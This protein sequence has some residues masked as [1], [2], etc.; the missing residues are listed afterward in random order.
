[1]RNNLRVLNWNCRGFWEKRH[2]IEHFSQHYDIISLSETFL[3]PSHPQFNLQ[4]FKYVRIDRQTNTYG[5]G[6]IV[7]I[8]QEIEYKRIFISNTPTKMECVA[9]QLI[10]GNDKLSLI[11]VYCPPNASLDKLQYKN[12]LEEI[13]TLGPSISSQV[14]SIARA[15]TGVMTLRMKGVR[16]CQNCYLTITHSNS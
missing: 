15:M 5:G 2:E 3:K 10:K 12:F 7:F 6:I 4:G 14:T 13:E 16:G 1:M 11:S 9:V 8:G